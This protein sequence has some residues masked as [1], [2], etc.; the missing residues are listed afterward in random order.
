MRLYIAGLLGIIFVSI[1]CSGSVAALRKCPALYKNIL[2]MGFASFAYYIVVA[3]LDFSSHLPR[4][5]FFTIVVP[6]GYGFGSGEG[7]FFAVLSIQWFLTW[8]LSCMFYFLIKRF[9][10][11]R[12][13]R[14]PA[15]T[16]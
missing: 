6:W 10:R 8:I 11:R 4:F 16:Q 7:P 13:Q 15:S 1:I 2:L 5:L 9:A 12:C 14:S 3:L